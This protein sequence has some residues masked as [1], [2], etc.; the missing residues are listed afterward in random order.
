MSETTIDRYRLR[1]LID[2]SSLTQGQL[3]AKSKVS[4]A[5]LSRLLSGKRRN[6]KVETVQKLATALGV[7]VSE[8][9]PQAIPRQITKQDIDLSAPDLRLVFNKLAELPPEDRQLVLDMI[10]PLIERADQMKRE[11]EKRR[12]ES[13]EG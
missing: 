12:G 9:I 5:H 6:V 7:D 10:R 4:Q 13:G 11:R 2:R 1:A 3:A 8:L